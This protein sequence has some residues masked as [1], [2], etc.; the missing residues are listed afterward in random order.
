MGGRRDNPFVPAPPVPTGDKLHKCTW[1]QFKSVDKARLKNHIKEKHQQCDICEVAFKTPVSLREHMRTVHDKQHGT[2]IK[3]EQCNFSALNQVHLRKHTI[4][5]HRERKCKANY[6]QIMEKW[7]L[8]KSKQ[9]LICTR[10][11]YV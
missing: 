10:N 9:L 8:Q 7:I 2:T 3:C 1:C 6:M 11:H 5:H 4:K